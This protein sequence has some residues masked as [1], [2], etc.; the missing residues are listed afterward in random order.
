MLAVPENAVIDSG[1]K[2][3]VI[4]DM[5][6][7]KFLPRAVK[8]G[9]RGQGFVQ[10]REGLADGD[11]IVT[12]ANFLIDAESNLKAALQGLTPLAE[13]ATADIKTGEAK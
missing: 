12:S 8:T 3:A 4:L 10:I 6:D 11:K 5:G 9:Q 2:Q 13:A 7:G 1:D